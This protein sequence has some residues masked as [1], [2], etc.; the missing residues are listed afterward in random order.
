M[1]KFDEQGKLENEKLVSL[2][3]A[4]VSNDMLAPLLK[5]LEEYNKTSLDIDRKNLTDDSI[6]EQLKLLGYNI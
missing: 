3:G 1:R 4:P 2:S 5:E 6:K